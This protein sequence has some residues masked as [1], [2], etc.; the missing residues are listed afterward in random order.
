MFAPFPMN[1]LEYPQHVPLLLN[2]NEIDYMGIKHAIG[3]W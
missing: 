2:G 1:F 3:K